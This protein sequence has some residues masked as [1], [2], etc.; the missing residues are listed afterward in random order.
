MQLVRNITV[1]QQYNCSVLYIFKIH[2]RGGGSW[3]T[4]VRLTFSSFSL[5]WLTMI[6]ADSNFS[7]RASLRRSCCR[8]AMASWRSLSWS[9]LL[10]WF[11]RAFRSLAFSSSNIRLRFSNTFWIVLSALTHFDSDD[12]MILHWIHEFIHQQWQTINIFKASILTKVYI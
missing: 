5:A 3:K 1:T 4:H 2:V 7:S 6:A 9:I 10:C 8:R 12:L 11:L